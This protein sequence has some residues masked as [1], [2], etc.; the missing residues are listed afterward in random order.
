MSVGGS[1]LARVDSSI[2]D[3]RTAEDRL[4]DLEGSLTGTVE[5]IDEVLNDPETGLSTRLDAAKE[6]FDEFVPSVN[7]ELLANQEA[8]P[9]TARW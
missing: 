6:A 4:S 9:P 7:E 1:R 3:V 2:A 8:A 5:G